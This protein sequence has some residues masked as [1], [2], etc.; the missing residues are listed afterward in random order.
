MRIPRRVHGMHGQPGGVQGMAGSM[1]LNLATSF[2]D[3]QLRIFGRGVKVHLAR[4]LSGRF[5]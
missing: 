1:T 2:P 5:C 3:A 4:E